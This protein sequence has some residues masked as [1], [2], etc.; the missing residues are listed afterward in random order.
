MKK[1]ITF[2]AACALALTLCSCGA[3]EDSEA[4][5]KKVTKAS[6]AVVAEADDNETEAPKATTTTK[7][8][9]ESVEEVTEDSEPAEASAD[10]SAAEKKTEPTE[11][12]PAEP[13]PEKKT[14]PTETKPAAT[15]PVQTTPKQ[16]QP[17]QTKPAQTQPKQTTPKQTQPTQ[18]QPKQTQPAAPQAPAAAKEFH[19]TTN[20]QPLMNSINIQ[21]VN[22]YESNGV[23]VMEAYVINGFNRTVWDINSVQIQLSDRNGNVFAA[24]D[25]GTL[26]N[27]DGST[28]VIG[29]NSYVPW[30]FTFKKDSYDLTNADLSMVNTKSSCGYN[31]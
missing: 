3:A 14:T 30:T 31:Y 7:A 23:L 2:I 24:A 1:H 17:A 19:G 28:A 18:T 4:A 10:S 25:F 20:P 5:V 13:K 12:K 21:S 26:L 8:A 11:T 27:S 22:I 15:Q 29:A 9:D 6:A 16:T